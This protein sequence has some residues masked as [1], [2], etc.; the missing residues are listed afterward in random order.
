[1]LKLE[2]ML[3][4]GLIS[5]WVATDHWY[6]GQ[7]V[8]RWTHWLTYWLI[9]WLVHKMYRLFLC[10]YRNILPP[11]HIILDDLR[12]D[13]IQPAT[14]GGILTVGVSKN[15]TLAKQCLRK[16]MFKIKQNM[17]NNIYANVTPVHRICSHECCVKV[18]VNKLCPCL[19]HC[20]QNHAFHKCFVPASCNRMSSW[21]KIPKQ[22]TAIVY[23]ILQ[24]WFIFIIQ[25][26]N[27]WLT[28]F[29]GEKCIM[30]VLIL[31]Y[32]TQICDENV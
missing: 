25:N 22:M 5:F 8:H 30:S 29:T 27:V 15:E 18:W 16:Y 3:T 23:H 7:C 17:V 14:R 24:H 19:S 26:W 21:Q 32:E 12:T 2:S 13:R 1:M 11:R 6:T 20:P 4:D 10:E 9:S 31:K 28:T